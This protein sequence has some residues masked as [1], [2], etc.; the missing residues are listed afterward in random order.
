MRVCL[1]GMTLHGGPTIF[2]TWRQT[3]IE[4]LW[5]KSAA[6]VVSP[7]VS[8]QRTSAALPGDCVSVRENRGKD[9]RAESQGLDLPHGA[10]FFNPRLK[11]AA[12]VRFKVSRKL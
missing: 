12:K 4:A 6:L 9:L 7:C 11:V 8:T 3:A 1:E 5:M 2:I 10:F